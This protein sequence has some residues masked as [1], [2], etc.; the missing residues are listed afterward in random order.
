MI[1]IDYE[2][3]RDEGDEIRVF[4]PE[5]SR[6]F[7]NLTYIEGPN[8]VG[9]STIMNIIALS[10][11][12][13]KN[14]KISKGL[15]E[16]LKNLVEEHQKLTFTI[17]ITNEDKSLTLISRKKDPEKKEIILEEIKANNQKRILTPEKFNR[18]YN[19]IYDIPE[20]PTQRL[21]QLASEVKDAQ[22]RYGNRIGGLKEYVRT[23]LSDIQAARDPNRIKELE[24]EL[25]RLGREIDVADKS[26][27]KLKEELRLLE[28]YTYHRLYYEYQKKVETLEK[29]LKVT[30]KKIKNTKNKVKRERTQYTNELDSAQNKIREMQGIF[31]EVSELLHLTL[32]K[33]DKNLLTS[34]EEINLNDALRELEFAENFGDLLR[35]FRITL[36]ESLT[37]LESNDDTKVAE[38]YKYLIQVL[39]TYKG[40]NTQ[41]LGKSI[42]ELLEELK[43]SAKKYD[44]LNL[45]KGNIKD[46]INSLENLDRIRGDLSNNLFKKI[47]SLGRKVSKVSEIEGYIEDEEDWGSEHQRKLEDTQKKRGYYSSRY[48]DVGKPDL[49]QI[50]EECGEKFERYSRCTEEQLKQKIKE[51][52]E[53]IIDNDATLR[54]TKH[55]IGRIKPELDNLRGKKP[56][57]YQ[58]YQGKLDELFKKLGVLDAKFKNEYD[59]YIQDIVEGRKSS[60]I[61]EEQ[62]RYNNAVFKFLAKRLDVFWHI[63]KKVTAKYVNLIEG[64]ISTNEGKTIYLADMGTGQSQSAY[65]KSLLNTTDDRRIIALFDE[66]A[67][68]DSKSLEPI[69]DQFNRLYADEHLLMGLVVQK[70]EKIKVLS[71][72]EK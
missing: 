68:M 31:D 66:V 41:L 7:D 40:L 19:L 9:K 35:E 22:T 50:K 13:L 29:E 37:E 26:N 52:E 12:G 23:I 47:R 45:E 3:E 46:A 43:D 10:L 59:T 8:S 56:H 20:N 53:G 72:K 69:F 64:V 44:D 62:Q 27:G 16:K 15:K 36:N 71:K 61:S 25:K 42:S 24:N 32:P 63:D 6:E 48:E 1:E 34:W 51:L 57:K 28:E 21:N 55:T 14:T 11:H 33:E 38:L 60:S 30:T 49:R 18:E 54:N 70:G 17:K 2:L 39:E 4:K 58:E 67:M 65:L 5:I